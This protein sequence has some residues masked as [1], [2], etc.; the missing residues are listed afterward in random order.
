MLAP[1]TAQPV[2]DLPGFDRA[3]IEGHVSLLHDMAKGLD[4]VLI[5][6]AFEAGGHAQSSGSGLA[7]WTAWSKR[8]WG[9]KIIRI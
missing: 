4:G 6:A 8:S 1:D 5:L 2:L 7:T 3:A 9:L